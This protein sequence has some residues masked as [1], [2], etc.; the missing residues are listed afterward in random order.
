[1]V[2]W[3]FVDCGLDGLFVVGFGA[4]GLCLCWVL[5]CYMLL[6]GLVGMLVV[7]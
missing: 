2:D 4:F 5:L 6:I 7:V 3:E 1:M